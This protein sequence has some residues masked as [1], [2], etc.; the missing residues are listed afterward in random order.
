MTFAD[1]SILL[2]DLGKTARTVLDET[3][4]GSVSLGGATFPDLTSV[5]TEIISLEGQYLGSVVPII[6]DEPDEPDE[7]EDDY[8]EDEDDVDI[9]DK[10]YEA[11]AKRVAGYEAEVRE[12]RQRLSILIRANL[13]AFSPEAQSL[14]NDDLRRHEALLSDRH[15]R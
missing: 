10:Y 5:C 7:D 14:L 9:L 13:A 6:F 11:A 2:N 8:D 15:A 12:L 4:G 1:V 3:A